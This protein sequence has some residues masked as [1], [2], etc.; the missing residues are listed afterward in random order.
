[1]EELS[2]ANSSS[3]EAIE[4]LQQKLE[5]AEALVSMKSE[6]ERLVHIVYIYYMAVE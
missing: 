2:R 1:L 5:N 4:K 6:S 3:K